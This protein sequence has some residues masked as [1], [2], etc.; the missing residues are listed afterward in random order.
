MK[1]R[2]R[3]LILGITMGILGS[4][5]GVSAQTREFTFH[6]NTVYAH[7]KDPNCGY[8]ASK[9]DGERAAYITVTKFID[10]GSPTISMWVA[11]SGSYKQLTP[12]WSWTSTAPRKKIG[13]DPSVN[14]KAGMMNQ[15]CAEQFGS[16]TVVI[17]GRWTP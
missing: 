17:G 8:A 16:G 10:T 6:M 3:L 7:G 5:T 2:M 14:V 9:A 15:L 12:A 4:A 1:K 11:P 13:Y